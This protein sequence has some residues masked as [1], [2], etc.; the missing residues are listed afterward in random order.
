MAGDNIACLV[1]AL[2]PAKARMLLET[3][4]AIPKVI[5]E[6]ETEICASHSISKPDDCQMTVNK[7][8]VIG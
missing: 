6:M 5:T 7:R 4:K 2:G 8:Q 1:R 3:P